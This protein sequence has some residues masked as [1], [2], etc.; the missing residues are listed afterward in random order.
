MLLCGRGRSLADNTTVNSWIEQRAFVTQAPLLLEAEFPELAANITAALVRQRRHVGGH[1]TSF[2]APL[3]PDTCRVTCSSSCPCLS[4]ADWCSPSDGVTNSCLQADLKNVVPPSPAGMNP[5]KSL[6]API[7][8]GDVELKIGPGGGIVS[9]QRGSGGRQWAGLANPIGQFL[10]ETYVMEDYTVFLHDIGS[11]IGDKGVWPKHTAGPFAN[12]TVTCEDDANF[13]KANFSS[14]N[15]KRRSLV[16]TVTGIWTKSDGPDGCAVV[17]EGALPAEANSAAGAPA[18]VVAKL[19]VSAMGSVFDWDFVQVNK[20]PTRLP[21]STFFSFNPVVSDP[22]GWG[23]T[24]LGSEMDPLDVVGKLAKGPNP[25]S[26]CKDLDTH[27]CMPFT[28]S[29][30]RR[31]PMHAVHLFTRVPLALA[32]VLCFIDLQTYSIHSR[33]PRRA[34]WLTRW[35]PLLARR[36]G[37]GVWWLAAPARG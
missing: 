27:A 1:F 26:N 25:L 23:L 17:I 20:R 5:V 15:P 18:S 4:D 30:M 35:S 3:P 31:S 28:C 21:E 12:N 14:A 19:T 33:P 34:V 10:Y 22:H 11:R 37:L 24:V 2:S 8:C 29:P 32:L 16:P 9:L 13:C 36:F 6:T 7:S